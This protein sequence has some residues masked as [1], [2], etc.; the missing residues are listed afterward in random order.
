MKL[1]SEFRDPQLAAHLIKAMYRTSRRAVR[2]MELCGTHTVAISKNG[3]RPMIPSHISLPP[4]PVRKVCVT[5]Q[6]A[7]D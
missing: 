2:L 3:L 7:V 5:S 4:G 6:R 1:V